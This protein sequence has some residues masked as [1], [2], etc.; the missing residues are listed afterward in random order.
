MRLPQVGLSPELPS[1]DV[2]RTDVLLREAG[3]YLADFLEPP[4]DKVWRE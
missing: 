1:D 3:G 2:D 4:A